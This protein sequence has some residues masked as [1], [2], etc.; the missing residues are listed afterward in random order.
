MDSD[1]DNDVNL[2]NINIDTNK[3]SI[4]NSLNNDLDSND[5]EENNSFNT[6]D[7]EI[8]IKSSESEILVLSDK[9]VL[10]YDDNDN[11]HY[12]KNI[13]IEDIILTDYEIDNLKNN[14]L[15][16]N[17]NINIENSNNN[18]E[19]NTYKNIINYNKYLYVNV[20]KYLNNNIVDD[21]I[22]KLDL[23]NLDKFYFIEQFETKLCIKNR[24]DY[25]IFCINN[26]VGLH[27]QFKY[28]YNS[29]IQFIVGLYFDDINYYFID[30]NDIKNTIH[31]FLK[32]YSHY[33]QYNSVNIIRDK[34]KWWQFWKC[35][36]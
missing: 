25:I 1:D 21:K 18:F 4:N 13:F 7:D 11:L 26:F 32:K 30:E 14:D 12:K 24:Y 29:F 27:I 9:N 5:S 19:N 36:F 28:F 31:L 6:S 10:I 2:I 35:C 34:Y 17:T 20:K 23:N 8:N 33:Y 3:V 16:N 22:Y 15:E